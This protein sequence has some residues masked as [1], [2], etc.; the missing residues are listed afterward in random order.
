MCSTVYT[1]NL[2]TR[3][4]RNARTT[5]DTWVQKHSRTAFLSLDASLELGD[6]IP[7]QQNPAT[8]RP[9]QV[10]SPMP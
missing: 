8:D 2:S 1:H 4:H 3:Y 9:G 10:R 7:A 5:Q 6:R